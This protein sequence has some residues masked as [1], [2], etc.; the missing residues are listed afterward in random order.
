[1]KAVRSI[2]WIVTTAI[3]VAFIAMNWTK[4]PVNFWPL[5][6]G[7]Y[8]HFDWPVGFVAIFFFLLGMLPVWLYFRAVRWR[9]NRRIA[10]LEN[11]LRAS[12]MPSINETGEPIASA[13]S[14]SSA[15]SDDRT[16]TAQLSPDTDTP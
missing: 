7:N 2:S 12:S 5:D 3:L 9:L 11:T 13:A 6:D 8:I 16:T 10:S 15:T 14:V 1:M 4:V